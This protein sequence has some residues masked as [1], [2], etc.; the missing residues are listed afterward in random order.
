M[1]KIYPGQTRNTT[2]IFIRY[3][4]FVPPSDVS[5]AARR[6]PDSFHHNDKIAPFHRIAARLLIIFG[7]LEM[8]GFKAFDIHHQTAI[9]GMEKLHQLTAAAYEDEY[10]T[11][12]DTAAH[13]LVYHTAEGTDTL[14]HISP[15]GAEKIPHRI[16]QTEHGNRCIG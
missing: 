10:I 16:I 4:H 14:A 9:L 6:F 15:A 5:N 2:S 11:V 13:T 1:Y 12:P 8:T 3:I 7:N